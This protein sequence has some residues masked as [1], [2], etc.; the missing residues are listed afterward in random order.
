M[1]TVSPRFS[2]CASP[3]HWSLAGL[4]ELVLVEVVLLV[5]VVVPPVPPLA[6][7]ELVVPP[8]PPLAV[9]ELVVPPVPLAVVEL[10]VPLAVVPPAPPLPPLPPLGPHPE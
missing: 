2:V 6:V 4:P 7:V 5:E 1:V 10:V 8:V 3:G 9:V